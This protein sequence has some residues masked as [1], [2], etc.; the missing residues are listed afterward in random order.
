MESDD[1]LFAVVRYIWN[2]PVEARLVDG[3]TDYPWSS[4]WS[5]GPASQV[6]DDAELDTLMP[7]SWR[8]QIMED[9]HV[10]ETSLTHIDKIGRPPRHSMEEV[11]TLMAQ[12]FGRDAMPDFRRLDEST[13][14]RVVR[15][16]RMRSI[17][18][19]QIAAVTGLSDSTIR[20][21]HIRGR[22]Q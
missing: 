21:L 7:P 11:R 17:P 15:E 14:Q 12:S 16:L 9:G 1:Y 4:C 13:Q 3:A 18:Y 6:V 2:N 22:I 8:T 19:S 20:R 10:A 5:G